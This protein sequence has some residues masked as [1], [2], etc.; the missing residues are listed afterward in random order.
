[1]A[2]IEH[3]LSIVVE[4]RADELRVAAGQEPRMFAGGEARPLSIPRMSERDVRELLGNLLSVE[5]QAE[6]SREGQA[7]FAYTSP[8]NGPFQVVLAVEPELRASFLKADPKSKAPVPVIPEDARANAPL[9]APLRSTPASAV[10]PP[11]QL[12]PSGEL[13]RRPLSLLLTQ[14][15]R[16]RA[17][18][19][20]L[21][22]GEGPRVRI[23]GRLRPLDGQE[24][25]DVTTLLDLEPG[26]RERLERNGSVDVALD[27]EG[28][29]RVRIHAY[30]AYN[31]VAAAIRLL[32]PAAP[33][34]G[35]LGM[36]VPLDDLALLPHGLV[37]LCGPAGS[38]KSTTL[39]A[40]A[41]EA[42]RRR[43]IVL[44]TLE[45]PIEYGLK[46]TDSSL[47]RRR[48]VGRDVGTFASG[49]RDA[50]RED[51]DVLLVGEMRDQETISLA[52]TAAET[53]HLVLASM[54]S[55]S[56]SSAI[57]RI[58]DSTA[59]ER[60]QQIKSQLA[61]SLRAVVAQRLLP[62][63]GREGRVPVCEVIRGTAAVAS[64]I[65]EGRTAQL[66][67]IAQSSRRDGMLSLERCLADN[68]RA[69]TV[70]LEEAR[71]AAN[72]VSTLM[73]YMSDG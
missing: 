34:L 25:A 71:A 69:G 70:S 42:L 66:G 32:P 35:A 72:D 8:T 17:S 63:L 62:R 65:R 47:L 12:K 64:V 73:L 60:Q 26:A 56:A 14:A 53:G 61:D 57:Q 50:L 55:R 4:R 15:S 5:R 24:P 10:P 27:V 39:A 13:E 23:D 33:S 40:L 54:H 3:L 67:T 41:Q 30:S 31:G 16:L 45:D 9:P 20:H 59:P 36:P 2:W 1:M 68:V 18:D 43:S 7:T 52:L 58:F 28:V 44:V 37:L 11:V 46:A 38:G 49:L 48:Q 29:G 6:A 22:D 51:P 19:L 21:A